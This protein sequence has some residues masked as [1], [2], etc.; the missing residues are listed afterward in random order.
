MCIPKRSS[1]RFRAFAAGLA[2]VAALS[3]TALA[4]PSAQQVQQAKDR[5]NRLNNE[6]SVAE[7]HLHNIQAKANQI[8]DEL[9]VA[10]NGLDRATSRYL[11]TKGQLDSA[12]A[13]YAAIKALLDARTRSAYME[14]S[15][16]SLEF[17]LGST[18]FADLSDRV[19]YMSALARND[20]DLAAQAESLKIQ[21]A[22]AAAAE[23]KLRQQKTSAVAKVQ[24]KNAQVQGNLSE[25]QGIVNEID[26]KRAQATK[27]YNSMKKKYQQSITPPALPPSGPPPPGYKGVFQRCPVGDPK[28][29]TDSFGAPRYA[30]GFHYHMGNDIMAPAGVPIYAPF[31]GVAR[32]D[33]N[34]LGGLAVIVTGSAGWVYNAHLSAYTSSSSGSVHAGDVIGYVGNS[35]DAVGGPTHDH[36]EFHP[37]VM[38]SS[39][40]ASPYGYSVIGSAINP[41]P[42]LIAAC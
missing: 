38:P 33:P 11:T 6:I 39:W 22:S 10:Q 27:L 14:G 25:Q 36:F 30:G 4:A 1:T 13:K 24:E 16:S 40:P 42:L 35:G 41:Y 15:G 8:A 29:Q 23:E 32:Q 2:L 19:E 26:R 3:G 9:Y 34:T 28:A 18:S 21:L 17:I 37:S 5:L 20:A 7:G 31:D 12:K